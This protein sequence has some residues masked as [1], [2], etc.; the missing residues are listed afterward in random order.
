MAPASH[1]GLDVRTHCCGLSGARAFLPAAAA[2]LR[3][4]GS[5]SS[6][7]GLLGAEEVNGYLISQ[8]TETELITMSWVIV[9]KLE[10][11]T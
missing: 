7:A 8:N 3:P 5:W 4:T 2:S 1:S 11:V 9:L 10:L 6:K